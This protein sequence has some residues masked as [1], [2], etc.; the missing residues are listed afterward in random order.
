MTRP[1]A[2]EHFTA[3]VTA[4]VSRLRRCERRYYEQHY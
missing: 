3:L 4:E 1:R 2:D